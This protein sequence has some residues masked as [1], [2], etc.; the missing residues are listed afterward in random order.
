MRLATATHSPGVGALILLFV[1]MSADGQTKFSLVVP[2]KLTHVSQRTSLKKIDVL[3]KAPKDTV[4]F[5]TECKKELM[6]VMTDILED[7]TLDTYKD[8]NQ[9]KDCFEAAESINDV[10][11]D[12]SSDIR[13]I[14]LM[15][16]T[17]IDPC[18]LYTSPSP[19][20]KRQSRMPSSA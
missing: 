5:F 19:R 20:D 9:T 16:S 7:T 15:A 14:H 10:L 4:T 17:E 3:L 6:A 8:S 11:N 18:L 1:M 12:I 2:G 13:Q